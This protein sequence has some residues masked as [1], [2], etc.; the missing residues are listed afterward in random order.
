MCW[1]WL[2]AGVVEREQY[3]DFL[4]LR[5]F[6]QT[7]LCRE[8]VALDRNLDSARMDRFLFSAPA[9]PVGENQMEGYHGARI[10]VTHE[11]ARR[12]ATAL[13]DAYPAPVAFAKLLSYA[14]ERAALES[15]LYGLTIGSFAEIHVHEY[16]CR[17]TVTAKPLA[18]RL[19]RY[20]ASL[21][22]YVTNLCHEAMQLDENGRTLLKLLD[23]TRDHAAIALELAAMPG[24]PA[25]EEIRTHLSSALSQLARMALLEG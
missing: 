17:K 25:I 20:Q 2:D 14:G 12:V 19:A 23:G 21:L 3:I 9:R 22:P 8:E 18:S 7:L 1:Q 5:R 13:G 15:I 6:R 10:T 24:A 16:P 11:A 4:R